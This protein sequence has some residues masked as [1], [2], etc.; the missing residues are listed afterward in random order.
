MTSGKSTTPKSATVSKT[1]GITISPRVGP[2]TMASLTLHLRPHRINANGLIIVHN[3]LSVTYDVNE[4]VSLRNKIHYHIGIPT[5]RYKE[6]V[7][8]D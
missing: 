5:D 1:E 7:G 4:Q 8:A 6:N 2:A 3:T